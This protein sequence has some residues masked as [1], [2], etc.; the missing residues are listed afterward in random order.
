MG[1]KFKTGAQRSMRSGSGLVH[2]F[3]RFIEGEGVGLRI[4]GKSLKVA[5]H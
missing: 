1:G 4:G 5:A 3:Q 2:H